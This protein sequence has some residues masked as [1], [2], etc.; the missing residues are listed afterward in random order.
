MVESDKLLEGHRESSED[1][2]DHL[3]SGDHLALGSKESEERAAGNK[4]ISGGVVLSVV[5]MPA[6]KTKYAPKKFKG[7]YSEIERF[8][9]TYERLCNRFNVTSGKEKCETVRQYC[10]REVVRVI[11][12]LSGFHRNN[13][14]QLKS[15]LKNLYDAARNEHRY[16][17]EDL[18]KYVKHQ[19]KK[20]LSSLAKFKEYRRGFTTIGGW[21]LAKGK[22]TTEK[23]AKCFMAGIHKSFAKKLKNRLGIIRPH[24]PAGEPWEIEDIVKAAEYLLERK[25]AEHAEEAISGSEIEDSDSESNDSDDDEDSEGSDSDDEDDLPKSKSSKKRPKRKENPLDK[26]TRSELPPPPSKKVR[27]HFKELEKEGIKAAK[28]DEIQS[29]IDQLSRMSLDDTS[30]PSLYYRLGVLDPEAQSFTTPPAFRRARAP[31]RL[32]EVEEPRR[33]EDMMCFG[34]GDKGHGLGTCPKINDLVLKGVIVR[35]YA[36]KLIMKDGARIMRINQEP[37]TKAIE[38]MMQ[39][40]SNYVALSAG[41]RFSDLPASDEESDDDQRGT[42]VYPAERSERATRAAARKDAKDKVYPPSKKLV[43][44]KRAPRPQLPRPVKKPEELIDLY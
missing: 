27:E 31:P 24:Q 22:I 21:L 4:H 5:D 11:E 16:T 32:A 12:G 41:V 36:G 15:E 3:P 37:F 2:F 8:L 7:H 25:R 13:W 19:A 34:C 1:S 17:S 43:P 39:P 10:S 6:P 18:R 20:R 33:R 28:T 26:I 42:V 30:Y 9:E 44:E 14:S 35:D 40:V 29:I 23:H 38:R